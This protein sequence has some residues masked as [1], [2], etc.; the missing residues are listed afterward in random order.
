MIDDGARCPCLSGLAFG[1]CCAPVHRGQR[2][3]ATAEALM[4]SRY[5][6]FAAGDDAWL[7]ASW[8]PSTRPATLDLDDDVVWRRL[9][10]LATRAGGPF[11]DAGEVEFAAAWR[12]AATGERGRLHEV[13]RFI[14]EHGHWLYVDG[15]L[16][17]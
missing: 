11:D 4:R 10:I 15:D 2:P 12:H 13:S 14:R 17:P 6:A 16:L 9:D 7:R 3:A 1:E 8:H 5:S